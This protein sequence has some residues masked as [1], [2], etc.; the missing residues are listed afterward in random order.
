MVVTSTRGHF[1]RSWWSISNDE[2]AAIMVD[3]G[4]SGSHFGLNFRAIS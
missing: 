2:P 1:G 3:I 4:G